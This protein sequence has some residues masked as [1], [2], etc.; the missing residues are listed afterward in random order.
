MQHSTATTMTRR[1][2]AIAI[3]IAAYAGGAGAAELGAALVRS[4]IGQP[5]VADIELTALGADDMTGLQVR[6]ASPD[7]YR[8]GNIE[9]NPALQTL[10]LSIMRR[11]QR[12]FLHLTSLRRIDA[13]YLNLYLE[14]SVGGRSAVRAATLWLTPD[15]A[16]PPAAVP[17][18]AAAPQAEPAA[19]RQ[20][21]IPLHRPAAVPVPVM[22]APLSHHRPEPGAVAAR[23]PGGS[24]KA[25]ACAPAA[26]GDATLCIALEEKNVALNSKLIE[27]ESKIKVLQ[28]ELMPASPRAPAPLPA[29]PAKAKPP[30]AVPAK[31]TP[32]GPTSGSLLLAGGAAVL[33]LLIGIGVHLYRRRKQAPAPTVASK[34]WVLLRRPFRRKKAAETAEEGV[35]DAI[36]E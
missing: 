11:D 33:L 18:V 17:P 1:A 22:A 13:D 21:A 30:A 12:Q 5:L 31:K 34:Y 20:R 27:L 7:V 10:R 8:G 15:P 28:Q 2:S 6:L 3:A 36:T 4:H 19:P 16:P 25:A 24:R 9:M 26:S 23:R 32:A 29:A 35:A 14:L